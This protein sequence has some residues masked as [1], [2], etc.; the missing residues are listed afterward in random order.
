VGWSGEELLSYHRNKV[1]ELCSD[2]VLLLW[3]NLPVSSSSAWIKRG[4]FLS[5]HCESVVWS[6]KGSPGKCEH[7]P[8]QKNTAPLEMFYSHL[9]LH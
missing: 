4:Y 5:P 7:F 1:S 9:G 8:P 3:T 6:Y 2:E